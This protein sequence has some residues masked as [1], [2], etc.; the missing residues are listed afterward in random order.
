[1]VLSDPVYRHK[2]WAGNW[3]AFV[4]CIPIKI[5]DNV[6]Q[7]HWFRQKENW[8]KAHELSTSENTKVYGG[9]FYDRTHAYMDDLEDF[10]EAALDC[11]G[12]KKT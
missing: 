10:H 1:M 3:R 12:L 8:P 2:Y 9:K 5:S 7:V 11:S 6:E 4:N